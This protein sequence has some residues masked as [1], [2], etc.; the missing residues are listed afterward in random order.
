MCVMYN[1]VAVF[2]PTQM[3]A[4]KNMFPDANPRL[5]QGGCPEQGTDELFEVPED[6]DINVDAI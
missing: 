6:A 3:V 2:T 5:L 1:N 4:Y